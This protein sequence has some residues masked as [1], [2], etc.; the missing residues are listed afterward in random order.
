MKPQ[1]ILVTGTSG[2]LGGPLAEK[3]AN[4]GRRVIGFD[5]AAPR[6][7]RP[8][9]EAVVGDL[10]DSDR[11]TALFDQHGFDG[12]VHCGGISGPMLIPDQPLEVCRIN[13]FATVHLLEAARLHGVQRLV[14]CSSV[15]AYGDMGAGPVDEDGAFH[16]IEVYGATK[17]A[18]DSLVHGYRA[19]HGLDAIAIRIAR[20][21]G[22][23]RT[24]ESIVLSLIEDALAGRRMRV[25]GDGS[26]RYH[27]VHRDDVVAA[28]NLALDVESTPQAAYNIAG[29]DEASDAEIAE[30]VRDLI[31]D[32]D[33]T[34]GAL[35]EDIGFKRQPLDI[36]A[37]GR[38]LGYV[39]Q[40]D[41]RAG[42][43]AYIDW[44]RDRMG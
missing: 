5:I 11:L 13:V 12:V 19:Q 42:I 40:I 36:A 37:A 43:A 25:P 26:Q 22:P 41:I 8:A 17:A 38:D 16:P 44:M 29:P 33:I 20:V 39:P 24:T 34:F 30:I 1:T 31:P 3:L 9:F 6:V 27:Y 4:E 18:C 35:G 14:Y 10:R 15:S 21:Y 32:T 2:M 28:L 23:G 7:N